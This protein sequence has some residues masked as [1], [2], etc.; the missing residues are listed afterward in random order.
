MAIN[1]LSKLASAITVQVGNTISATE[2]VDDEVVVVDVV[3]V[4]ALSAAV[5]PP[6][7]PPQATNNKVNNKISLFKSSP[8]NQNDD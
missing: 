2:L 3:V 4:L 7:P 8:H 1:A 6:P 5:P